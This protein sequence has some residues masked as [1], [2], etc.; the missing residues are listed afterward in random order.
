MV[1]FV[2]DNKITIRYERT[3]TDDLVNFDTNVKDFYLPKFQRTNQNTSVNL[4]PIVNSSA[5]V[6]QCCVRDLK[7]GAV[8]LTAFLPC[9]RCC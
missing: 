7:S 2:D 3:L 1:E 4:R 9:S 8:V 5:S 6:A